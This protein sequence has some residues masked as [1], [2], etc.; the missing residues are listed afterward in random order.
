MANEHGRRGSLA[1]LWDHRRSVCS[2]AQAA[3]KVR[4]GTSSLAK[5]L[6]LVF[7]VYS[8][9]V[10]LSAMATLLILSTRSCGADITGSLGRFVGSSGASEQDP[11]RV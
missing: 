8:I 6:F 2:M 5:R 7:T 11:H 9:R 3:A 4:L 1:S 10:S